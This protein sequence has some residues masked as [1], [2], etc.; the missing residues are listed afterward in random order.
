MINCHIHTFTV[1]HVPVDFLPLRLGEVFKIPYV[2]TPARWLLG[3]L[4]PFNNRD[5]FNRY[6]NFI[7]VANGKSQE[8]VFRFV[9]GRY[10]DQTRFIVLPMD[11]AYMGAGK[12][13]KDIT[14]QHE[15]LAEMRDKLGDVVIPF[16]A[17]DPRRPGV[18]AMLQHF[19]ENRRFRGIKVY[20]NLGYRPDD[21]VLMNEIWPYAVKMNLPV[22]THCSRG[23]PRAKGIR[24]EDLD[25][26]T[27]PSCWVPVLKKFPDL[28]VCLAHLGGDDEWKRYFAD[29]WQPT[30]GTQRKSWLADILDLIRSGQYPNLYADISY[31]VFRFEDYGPALKVFIADPTIRERILFGSD[32]YMTENERFEERMLSMKL[33]ALLGEEHF[34]Q[35]ASINPERYLG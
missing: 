9:Q 11:M 3:A 19:V 22:M 16:A 24:K 7:Q 15:Q 18:L 5:R 26:Y 23:G 35:I 25:R 29:T 4:N 8:E 20:P 14:K 2:R 21:P 17:V 33:R 1:D 28:R 6:A 32:Y 34:W 30:L 13:P 12:V 10:P 31:T 27:A